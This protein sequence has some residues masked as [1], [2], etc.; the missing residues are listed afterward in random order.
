MDR[1]KPVP[2]RKTR[3]GL[4]T[5]MD[6]QLGHHGETQQQSGYCEHSTGPT[7]QQQSQQQQLPTLPA[8]VYPPGMQPTNVQPPPGLGHSSGQ[9]TWQGAT[10]QSAP[11]QFGPAATRQQSPFGSQP[12]QGSA[13][14]RQQSPFGQQPQES[15]G[16]SPFNQGYQ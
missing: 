5:R 10:T 1:E 15:I 4:N 11:I 7:Q 3:L 9:Q 13:V 8:P 14:D 12:T 6:P 16:R 2:T